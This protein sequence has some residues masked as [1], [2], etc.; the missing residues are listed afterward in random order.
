MAATRPSI[1]PGDCAPASDAAID[2]VGGRR[3]GAVA[4][5]A[6]EADLQGTL[7]RT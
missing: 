2:P 4:E 7:I 3:G 1:N 6:R 5:I